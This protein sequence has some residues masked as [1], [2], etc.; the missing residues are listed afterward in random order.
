M[1][2]LP[3]SLVLRLKTRQAVLVT[4]LTCAELAGLP[5]WPALLERLAEWIEEEAAKRE[6]LA[7]LGSGQLATAAAL[8]R[9]LVATDAL[10]EVLVDTYPAATP[11][12]ET[13]RAVASAPWRGIIAT[14]YDGLWAKAL[15]EQGEKPERLAFAASAASIEPGRGRFLLQLFGRPDLPDTL[16]L[17]PSEI[18]AKLVASGA[19]QF[20]AGL[21]Q[22]WSFVFLGFRPGDPDLAMLAGRLLGANASTVD[23][24]LVTP[25]LSAWEARRVRA[26]TGL[27]PVAMEGTAEEVYQ[28][29]AETCRLAGD[30]PAPEDVE[31]WLERLTAEPEN[32]EAR[33]ML[34]Q[35]LAVLCE[36]KEWERFVAALINKVELQPDPKEQA[37]D[38]CE[39]GTVLE[40]ELGAPERAFP[41]LMMALH[42]SPHD[43]EL[44]TD[45]KRVAD[46]AGQSQAFHDELAE[47]EKET[48]GTPEAEQMSLS[49]ARLLADDPTRQEEAIAAFQK[50]L[51]RNPDHALAMA[52]L[53][54][55]LRK[56]E[57]WDALGTLLSKAAQRDPGNAEIAA[58]L[59]EV[60]ERTQQN[61]PLV[62]LLSDRLAQKPD[63]TPTLDKLE[64]L[65]Q[66]K[67]DWH[68]LAAMH[69]RALERNPEDLR[70]LAKLEDVYQQTQQWQ[71]LQALYEERLGK[72]SGDT[73]V[74]GKLEA[75][76]RQSEQW[77]A[78]ADHL[79]R[80]AAQM[81]S[82]EARP[83]QLE[84][85]GILIEKQ[86][87]TDGALAIARAFLPGDV[88][89]AA[90][91]LHQMHGTRYRQ[92][93]PPAG[94]GRAGARPRRPPARREAPARRGRAH[95]GPGRAGAAARRGGHAAP[96]TARRRS[97]GDRVPGGRPRLRSRA[98]PGRG[99]AAR[100]ARATGGLGQGRAALRAAGAQ[101]APKMA[102]SAPA[103]TNGR[104][105]ARTS[106]ASST[107]RRRRWPRP[108]PST[109]RPCRWPA[110]WPTCRR[111]AKPGPR[112]APNT[113]AR[114][115]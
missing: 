98:G 2:L 13:I 114:R 100:R 14:G 77:Q 46:A 8:L 63:D 97:A 43:A 1:H 62:E 22:K 39:A 3:E 64:T 66:K 21:Y 45:A 20:L 36:K 19:S 4:G 9:D 88:T 67:Q 31:A 105:V 48:A 110:S 108:R 69:Q 51:D 11:V 112:P 99:E 50:L 79:G 37:A 83:L 61:T 92:S 25:G 41:V 80:R 26:E 81:T 17:G 84:Q 74:L 71:A 104:R 30:K 53:E 57:R 42:L 76:Y 40:K 55:V 106:S 60:F 101:D 107:R 23:H 85:A 109:A 33:E 95:P 103:S 111:S 65:H 38:L 10:S 68:K 6:F 86:G 34:E 18:A 12:P 75:L 15:A 93:G 16:C 113:N 29:V 28:A 78:L 24:Y 72:D 58:K 90:E 49:V 87:D 82:E 47:I 7:L 96:G 115:A 73:A 52:G 27:I 70:A 56:N 91:D 94:P 5:G 44:L 35:G 59:E 32:E 89:A 54:G 102:R